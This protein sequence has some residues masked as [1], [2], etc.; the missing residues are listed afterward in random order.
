MTGAAAA[1]LDPETSRWLR[2]LGACGAEREAAYARL[3]ARLL[4]T[5]YGELHRRGAHSRIA[6]PELEDLAHEAAADALVSIRRRLPEFR[7]ESR[8]TTWAYKFA[9]FE[10]SAKLGRHHRRA[11][12]V[13]LDSEQ[14][15]RLP[16]N[17]DLDP[18]RQSE[19]RELVAALRES[20][21]TTLSE[22]QRRVFVAIVL[23][24]VPLDALVQEL[25][26][27]RNAIYKTL[28]DVRRKLRAR[29]AAGGYLT[30]DE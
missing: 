3:H 9:I 13:S 19:W 12:P 5:V 8:F 11:R 29:L 25:G 17:F 23:N 21:D 28:Y 10:V 2:A 14:W 27:N 7:G 18:A 22:H 4:R 30:S 26:T 24:A 1:T 20:V 16:G 6:G 15:D